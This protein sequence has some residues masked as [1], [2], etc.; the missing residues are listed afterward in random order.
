MLLPVRLNKVEIRNFRSIQH[1]VL[2]P[3]EVTTLIGKNNCGKSNIL[4]ALQFFFTASAK[5]AVV[6][7]VC[8]FA[9]DTGTW[10]ECTFD[11]LSDPEKDELGKYV[12][13]DQTIRVRR[14]LGVCPS[15]QFPIASTFSG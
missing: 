15:N 1:L 12:R 4:R 13:H 3:K 10:V 8:K 11:D 2:S 6:E 5:S 14:K 7:D 9:D